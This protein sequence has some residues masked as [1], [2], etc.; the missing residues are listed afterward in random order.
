VVFAVLPVLGVGLLHNEV[1][2]SLVAALCTIAILSG[3]EMV[4]EPRL[5]NRRRY[6]P[7]TTVLLMMVFVQDIGLVGLILAPPITAALQII[8]NNTLEIL[9]G[10]PAKPKKPAQEVNLLRDRLA[11]LIKA[12]RENG[13]EVSAELTNLTTRLTNLLDEANRL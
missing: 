3:L 13:N 12:Q 8:F 6:N 2:L 5:F 10:S 9:T 11:G 4:V 1:G 7:T